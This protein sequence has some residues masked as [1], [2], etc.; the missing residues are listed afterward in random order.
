MSDRPLKIAFLSPHREHMGDT[1][2]IPILAKGLAELGHSVDLLQ[3]WQEWGHVDFSSDDSDVRVVSLRTRWFA[4]VLPNI[5]KI[6]KWAS[7]RVSMLV[8][9]IAMMPGLI[10][11][12]YRS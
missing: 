4:P 2:S 8:L 12:L 10:T 7:Y 6:S 5:S 9:F 1:R 11:Y 3:A